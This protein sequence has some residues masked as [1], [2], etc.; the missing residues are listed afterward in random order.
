MYLPILKL[1]LHFVSFL[2][3]DAPSRLNMMLETKLNSSHY[4]FMWSRA[5]R[6]R[7]RDKTEIENTEML[8]ENMQQFL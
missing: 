5:E 1:A 4:T 8:E 2:F 6:E 3:A 7:G